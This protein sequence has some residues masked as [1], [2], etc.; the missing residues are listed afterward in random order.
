MLVEPFKVGTFNG[1][2]Q[3][4]YPEWEMQWQRLCAK[5]KVDNI[6]V[7]LGTREIKTVLDVGCGTG[8]VLSEIQRR[9][10]GTE[11][12]GIDVGTS[13]EHVDP[14]ARNL[15]LLQYDGKTIPFQDNSFDLTYSSHVLEHVLNPRMFLQEMSRVSKKVI[16]VE[17]PCEMHIR[18][19][20][21]SIQSSLDIGHINSYTVETFLVL[22]QTSGLE[23]MAFDIFD[24]SFELYRFFYNSFMRAMVTMVVRRVPFTISRLL[25]SRLFTYHCGALCNQSDSS[26]V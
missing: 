23:V 7:L 8:A 6:Q 18:R 4:K 1:H 10:L 14:Q 13:K 24:H 22:L 15:V 16:Y 2:Y 20:Y 11:H 9:K 17:V 21:R 3:G 26:F 5:A 19:T 25:S 12:I